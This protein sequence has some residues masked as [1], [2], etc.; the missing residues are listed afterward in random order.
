VVSLPDKDNRQNVLRLVRANGEIWA[1]VQAR[2]NGQE[3]YT[4]I[5][6]GQLWELMPRLA[7]LM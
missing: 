3:V 5:R 2:H 4:A 1:E 6:L 7:E